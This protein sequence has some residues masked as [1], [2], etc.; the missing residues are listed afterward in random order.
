MAL[1]LAR[2]VSIVLPLLGLVV[3]ALRFP[4]LPASVPVHFDVTGTPD[5]YG[6]SWSV[7]VL[8]GV[9]LA[10][11]IL[12]VVLSLRPEK[13][14]YPTP[15]AAGNEQRLYRVGEWMLVA[16]ALVIGVLF[17]GVLGLVFG[18]PGQPLLWVGI[19][20]VVATVIVGIRRMVVVAHAPA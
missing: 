17:A 15:P 3:V 6:P 8:A 7:L 1:K 18:L 12:M 11:A 10:V 5:R 19:A 16:T 20:A 9:W 14:N 4:S 13:L 2:I